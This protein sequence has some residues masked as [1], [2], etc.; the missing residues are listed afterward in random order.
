[1][2]KRYPVFA[3]C[4]LVVSCYSFS[5]FAKP[6]QHELKSDDRKTREKTAQDN[7]K[8]IDL[9]DIQDPAA[10]KAI[11]EIMNYLDLPYKK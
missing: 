1:M 4:V 7:V 6:E 8:Q 10:R 2:F 5:V 11:R 9:R 3:C